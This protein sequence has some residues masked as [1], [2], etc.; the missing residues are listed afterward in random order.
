MIIFQIM[1]NFFW[2]VLEDDFF[3]R[4][5]ERIELLKEEVQ[6]EDFLCRKG[7][8]NEVAFWVFDYPPEKELLMRY[9][10][11]KL[12]STLEKKSISALEI[13]LFD[14]CLEIINE[15]ISID[16]VIEYE[17]KKG[18]HDL[19]DKLKPII[20]PE[21][22]RNA[23]ISKLKDKDV[24]LIFL[25]GVGKIWPLIRAHLILNNLQVVINDVPLIMFYP[26]RY[27]GVDLSL[28]GKF[29]DNNYYRAFR[30]IKDDSV[31]GNM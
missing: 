5:E 11:S 14:L 25:T 9:T 3:M 18:S 19:L 7:L 27:S 21:T 20:K 2:S 30:L 23:V 26:G 16:K 4:I 8:G 24:E 12:V 29:Q 31:G 22:L 1:I 28:F 13:D 6:K 17:H 10:V 15:K